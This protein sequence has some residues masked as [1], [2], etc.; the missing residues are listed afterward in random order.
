MYEECSFYVNVKIS[1][2][3]LQHIVEIT[4]KNHIDSS[5]LIDYNCIILTYQNHMII[6]LL[7][8]TGKLIKY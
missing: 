7:Y 1:K 2:N 3:V 4:K 5:L 6:Y 8:N